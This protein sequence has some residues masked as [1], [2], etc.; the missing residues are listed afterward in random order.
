MISSSDDSI[1]RR[2]TVVFFFGRF[3]TFFVGFLSFISER[4]HQ[5]R[6][7]RILLLRKASCRACRFS[8]F[9]CWMT[10]SS[11]A[12]LVGAPDDTKAVVGLAAAALAAKRGLFVG[13]PISSLQ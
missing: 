2:F 5:L 11:A 8:S 12:N 6:T 9:V 4:G 13:F 10:D 7:K 3:R 1:D